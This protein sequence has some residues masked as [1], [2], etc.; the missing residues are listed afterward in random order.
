MIKK[1]TPLLQLTRGPSL[2]E[3]IRTVA[4]RRKID[5]EGTVESVESDQM[6]EGDA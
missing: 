1:Y 4:K 2:S 5:M 6:E 3:K